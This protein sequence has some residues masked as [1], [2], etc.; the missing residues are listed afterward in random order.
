MSMRILVLDDDPAVRLFLDRI[1]GREDFRVVCVESGSKALAQVRAHQFD[2][3]M[4]DKHLPGESG[5]EVLAEAR[6]IDPDLPAML[7]TAYPEPLLKRS[8]RLQGYLGKPFES[9]EQVV[10]MVRKTFRP[11]AEPEEPD[12]ERTPLSLR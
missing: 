5:L 6:K 10:Q 3:F 7:I 2:G 11:R 8:A 4:V 9:V 1:L 12:S